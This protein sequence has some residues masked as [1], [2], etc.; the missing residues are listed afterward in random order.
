[1]DL[2]GLN[3]KLVEPQVVEAFLPK[4]ENRERPLLMSG[5][6]CIQQQI[7]TK[8]LLCPV[9]WFAPAIPS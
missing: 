1:M 5:M 9:A 6:S 4:Y 2:G 8:H 7:F 3:D